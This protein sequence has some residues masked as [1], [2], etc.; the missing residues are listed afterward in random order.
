MY[1]AY[2]QAGI[3]HIRWHGLIIIAIIIIIILTFQYIHKHK[4]T[5]EGKLGKKGS[6][7]G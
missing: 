5:D 1:I 3:Q 7:G 6:T 2:V 4:E